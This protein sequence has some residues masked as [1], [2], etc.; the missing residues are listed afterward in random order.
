MTTASQNR[1]ESPPGAIVLG[2]SHGSLSIARSL[3]R[4][5]IPVCFVTGER[6]ITAASRY[7]TTRHWPVQS[8]FGR[9]EFLLQLGAR[10]GYDGWA[11]FAATDNDVGLVSKHSAKLERM[12]RLT[13]APWETMKH[14]YDKGLT[15][16][17]ARRTGVDLPWT[18]RP[19]HRSEVAAMDCSYPAILKPTVKESV[20]AFTQSKAWAVASRDELIRL[21]DA[22]ASLVDPGTILIQ[23]Q[24]PGTG[25]VQF[26]YAA[27]WWNAQPVASLIA[28]RLRQFPVDFGLSSTLVETTEAPAVEEASVRLLKD[29]AYHGLVEVEFKFDVRDAKYKL[30]DVNPRCWTWHHL[31]QK[32]GVDFSHIAWR[33]AQGLEITPIKA[34][35]GVRWL[36]F[37][38]DVLAACLEMRRGRLSLGGYLKSLWG[39]KTFAVFAWDDPIPALVELPLLLARLPVRLA[40]AHV[41]A[42]EQAPSA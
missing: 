6:S 10:L 28:R 23:D 30:L 19:Q 31:G 14:A 36:Y 21:Y 11:L 42:R 7:V 22:A 29:I 34:R 15:Y 40:R 2:G 16:Q 41:T 35:P 26:S 4:H 38:R 27:L 9:V 12:Y 37:S 17:L 1:T 3:G 8:D 13:C 25:E 39:P 5:G 20:N 32:A 18:A 33:A 24:I